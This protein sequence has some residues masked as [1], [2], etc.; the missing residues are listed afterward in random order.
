M[1]PAVVVAA[2]LFAWLSANHIRP[3]G[4]AP[5]PPAPPSQTCAPTVPFVQEQ[6]TDALG[7]QTVPDAPPAPPRAP[8]PQLATTNETTAKTAWSFTIER[9]SVSPGFCSPRTSAAS[10]VA[11]RRSRRPCT[12]GQREPPTTSDEY[13]QRAHRPPR[14]TERSPTTTKQLRSVVWC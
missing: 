10:S 11:W 5:M 1:A 7:M 9:S 2:I 14:S 13:Q 6:D 4:P 12:P 8:P 3:S